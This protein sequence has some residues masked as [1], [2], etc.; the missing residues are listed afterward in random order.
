MRL[1]VGLLILVAVA[2]VL[3]F[4]ILGLTVGTRMNQ[5]TI[6]L[7]GGTLIGLLI[8]VPCA[9]IVTYLA[10]SGRQNHDTGSGHWVVPQDGSAPPPAPPV[11]ETHNH[12]NT[13]NNY[14]TV[15]VPPGT[16][17]E[18]WHVVIAEQL[19]I[20]PLAAKAMLLSGS[21]EVHS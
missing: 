6:A 17:R 21:V 3:F 12:Y 10:V 7:L 11:V 18:M 9:S 5:N 14:I 20:S 1:I 16:P 13:T 8:A 15:N 2:V 19:Q 4:I